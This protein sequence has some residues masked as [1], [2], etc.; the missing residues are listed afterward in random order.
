MKIKL[1]LILLLL[2]SLL[3]ASETKVGDVILPFS[4]NDENGQLWNLSDNLNQNY[5]VVYFYPIALTGG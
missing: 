1:F 3:L 4:S 5:L 2:S